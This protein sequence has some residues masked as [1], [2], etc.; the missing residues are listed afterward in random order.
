MTALPIKV[1]GSICPLER[2][3]VML[4]TITNRRRLERMT[5]MLSK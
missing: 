2:S 1:I 5:S 4:P 3:T